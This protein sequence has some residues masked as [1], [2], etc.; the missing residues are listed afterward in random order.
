MKRCLIK[1]SLFG[2]IIGALVVHI[3]TL[4]ANLMLHGEPLVCMPTLT[5]SMGQVGAVVMQTVLGALFGMIASGGMCLFEIEEWSLLRAT[6][7]HCAL[8]LVTNIIISLLL[9]W[10]S[11][12]I[13]SIVIMSTAIIIAYTLIWLIMYI[14][15]KREVQEM[16]LLAEEYKKD[17]EKEGR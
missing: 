3:F 2:L 9:H 1:N 10:I 5:E 15:W 13:I 17:I 6:M 16:N 7:S 4:F 14:I 12:H 8:I 11:F